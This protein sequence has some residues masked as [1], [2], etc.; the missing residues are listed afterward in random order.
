[1][2]TGKIDRFSL[3]RIDS[4]SQFRSDMEMRVV[5]S[6]EFLSRLPVV[7]QQFTLGVIEQSVLVHTL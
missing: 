1:M 5:G 2:T 4:R 3:D 7:D 6:A